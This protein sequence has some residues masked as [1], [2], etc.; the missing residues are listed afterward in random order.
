MNDSPMQHEEPAVVVN[1][2][3]DE[4]GTPTLFGHRGKPIVGMETSRY[5]LLGKLDVDDPDALGN[6][7]RELRQTLLAD[8]F[9]N[10]APS[11]QPEA[12][13]TAL[14]FH[15]KDDLAEVR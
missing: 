14:A 2:F 9:F 8:P 1:Y 6:A 15:A 5:F 13:K 10:T 7:L 4:S 12:G 3:I 11:M